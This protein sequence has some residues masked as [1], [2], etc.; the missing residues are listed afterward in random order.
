MNVTTLTQACRLHAGHG[1]GA[2]HAAKKAANLI[3][4]C[5]PVPDVLCTFILYS[6]S[7]WAMG[8]PNER[9]NVLF[10]MFG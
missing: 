3:A 7:L 5:P 10:L 1:L 4:G 6:L 9:T 2:G 8:F